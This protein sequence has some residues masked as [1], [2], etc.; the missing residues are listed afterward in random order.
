MRAMVF[1]RYGE[2][3]VMHLKDVPVPE[4]QDGE[5]L[6]RVGYSGVNPADSKTRS[7]A[8]RTHYRYVSF[9]LVTGMDAAGVVERT[10]AN[11][12]DFRQGDRVITW[13]SPDWKTS[14]S[15]AEFVRAS[16]RN[17][18]PVPKSLNFAK[19]RLFPLHR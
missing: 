8:T 15:H 9:P 10:G 3:D 11:V 16:V 12:T 2:P 17:V 18:S 4:P 1:D 5:V 14:G 13:G 6:I 19:P 7:G